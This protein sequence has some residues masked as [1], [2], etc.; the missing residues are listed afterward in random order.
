MTLRPKE[1]RPK[2]APRA[3][4]LGSP[5]SQGPFMLLLPLLLACGDSLLSGNAVDQ[6]LDDAPLPDEPAWRLLWLGDDAVYGD[7][8]LEHVDTDGIEAV[9]GEVELDAPE[10]PEPTRW[11]QGAG[12]E[13]ALAWVAL[14]NAPDFVAPQELDG[15]AIEEDGTWGIAQSRAYLFVEGDRGAAADTLLAGQA[16]D[17]LADQAW[18]EWVPQL[19]ALEGSAAGALL[20]L[21]DEDEHDELLITNVEGLSIATEDAVMGEWGEGL[22]PARG[23]GEDAQ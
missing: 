23:C 17:D 21:E 11:N 12:F 16:E 14:V 19:V 22:V 5:P 6:L 15:P 1:I 2:M 7:C 13:W 3:F 10:I 8:E 18:V 4:A 20:Q 9:F